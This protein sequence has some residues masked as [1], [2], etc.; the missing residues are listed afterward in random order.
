METSFN[1]VEGTLI[2]TDH[3]NV[4]HSKGRYPPNR[5]TGKMV[6]PDQLLNSV[7]ARRGEG[8]EAKAHEYIK[9]RELGVAVY[10]HI[11]IGLFGIYKLN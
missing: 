2:M 3:A 11:T 10:Q 1:S 7:N 6:M 4:N 8:K 9:L 5:D